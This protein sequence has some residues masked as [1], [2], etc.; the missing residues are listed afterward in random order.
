MIFRF[1][2]E[3]SEPFALD[4]G[5]LPWRVSVRAQ[6]ILGFVALGLGKGGLF[7]ATFLAAMAWSEDGWLAYTIICSVVTLAVMAF[8]YIITFGRIEGLI[9]TDAGTVQ[10]TKRFPFYRR[11][12]LEPLANYQGVALISEQ[13]RDRR[14]T[15][16]LVLAHADLGL[17]LP[18][19]RRHWPEPPLEEWAAYA[20]AIGLP[21]LEHLIH[22]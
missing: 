18:L 22:R 20:K 19:W 12:H 16:T 14:V 15:H 4:L 13:D 2:L 11:T 17:E 10:L 8:G 9:D 5:D 6:V 21:Q 1:L 7:I 3:H